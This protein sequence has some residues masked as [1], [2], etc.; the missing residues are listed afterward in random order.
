[1]DWFKQAVDTILLTQANKPKPQPKVEPKPE[2]EA[3][4]QPDDTEDFIRQFLLDHPN[5]NAASLYNALKNRGIQFVKHPEITKAEQTKEQEKAAPG[6]DPKKFDSCVD[7]I[8][9]KQGSATDPVNAYA[10]CNAQLKQA[11]SATAH[12]QVLRSDVKTPKKKERKTKIKTKA[13]LESMGWQATLREASIASDGVGPT[14][15][16]VVLL[17]EGMGNMRDAFYYSK[18]ALDSAI[19]AFNGKKIFADHPST[20]EEQTRPERSVRDVLGHFEQLAVEESEGGQHQLVG[21]V[22]ILADK[23]YEW[24]RSLMRHSVDYAKQFP[25]QEFIGLSINASGDAN[26]MKI[27][28]M[29]AS[30]PDACK[31]KLVEAKENG[32]D[33]IRLVS[34]INEAV[35]CD[36]VTTA[37]AGGKVLS[38][39]ERNKQMETENEVVDQPGD[40]ADVQQDIELIKKMIADAMG[41][42]T[43]GEAKQTES[44][45]EAEAEA[46]EKVA[47]QAYQGAKECGMK[48]DEAM[49]FAKK[50]MTVAKKMAAKQTED[51]AKQ[52]E[53]E[54]VTKVKDG[55]VEDEA[56]TESE[57]EGM[58]AHKQV[59]SMK[60][61][62]L[63]LKGKLAFIE[64][65]NKK[66]EVLKY[67]ETKLAESKLPRS[68]TKA[69]R[70]A[71]GEIK[72]KEQFDSAFKIFTAA[73]VSQP[74][75]L[76][77]AFVEKSS[78]SETKASTLDFSG[79]AR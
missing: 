23:P 57:T 15:F 28:D 6:V 29:L 73:Q 27:D 41:E 51:E 49:D 52:A 66:V 31:P 33:S 9:K 77:F 8:T 30:A 64:N 70:E 61:E 46:M 20:I 4:V 13:K 17:Q 69:F 21:D 32:I 26:E 53:G 45:S 43:E 25:D 14:R 34:V 65:E 75:G 37:G 1:M 48:Q 63:A 3:T 22:V 12:A 47:M 35:S 59:E 16:R 60:K 2:V 44:E 38:L 7:Q 42:E 40:H 58:D 5:A 72:T 79:C 55:E 67:V 76:S 10:V 36:L 68:L 54:V 11:D 78:V 56:E 39:L 24:A 19:A 62:I 50:T 71:A 74:E 18:D